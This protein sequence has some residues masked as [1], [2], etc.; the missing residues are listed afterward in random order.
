MSW[1][2]YVSPGTQPDCDN[3]SAMS[4]GPQPQ[5]AGTPEIWNPLPDFTDV[6]ADHQLGDIQSV[7]N[8]YSAAKAGRLPAVSW[9]IPNG[10]QSEHPPAKVSVG[11]SYVTGLINS[12]MRG[13]DWGS[14]A[15]LLSWD[16]WGG[17]YDSVPPPHTDSNGY[18]LRVPGLVISPYAK[19]GFIDHQVL[20][21]DA[22]LKFIEDDFLAGQRLSPNTDG[23]PDSRP[24]VREN[25]PGLGNLYFDFNFKQQPRP[26]VLLPVNP[27][28]DLVG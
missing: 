17:F 4:C 24:D 7:A 18:G 27:T 26:P 6:H 16:D 11:Q 21:Q 20:S 19:S 13:P 28:T 1:R 15:I 14:T 3:A 25:A 10:A 22:Y 12:I 5:N 8:F 9:V 2:Y 23:R